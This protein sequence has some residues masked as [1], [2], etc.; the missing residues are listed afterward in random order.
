MAGEGELDTVTIRDHV[1]LVAATRWGTVLVGEWKAE[2]PCLRC[3]HAIGRHW[4]MET[5]AEAAKSEPA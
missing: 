5:T 4:R 3:G 2:T 1:G